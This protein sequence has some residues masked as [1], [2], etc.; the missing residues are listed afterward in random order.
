MSSS[1]NRSTAHYGA[2]TGLRATKDGMYLLST[3]ELRPFFKL[4]DFNGDNRFGC[5]LLV[6]QKFHRNP[7]TDM[8]SMLYV[9]SDYPFVIYIAVFL[10]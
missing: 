9:L 10:T 5:I 7:S 6:T 2:V 8:H 1:R 3:G 4:A